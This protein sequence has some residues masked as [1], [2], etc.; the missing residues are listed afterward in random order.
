[1]A[2]KHESVDMT[3]LKE[4]ERLLNSTQLAGTN[5]TAQAPQ[6]TAPPSGD[7]QDHQ[8]DQGTQLP[9]RR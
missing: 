6:A 9:R 1:M 3:T 4:V 5:E 7:G 2:N 8:S